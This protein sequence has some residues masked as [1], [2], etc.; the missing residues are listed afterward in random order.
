MS[1]RPHQISFG[2]AFGVPLATLA[3]ALFAAA[4]INIAGV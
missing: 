1:S 4:L 3:I 2:T